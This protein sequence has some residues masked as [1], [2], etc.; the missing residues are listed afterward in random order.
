MTPNMMNTHVDY[1]VQDDILLGIAKRTMQN[2]NE[3]VMD[4]Y[5]NAARAVADDCGVPVCDVYAK[6]KRLSELNVN[7]TALLSNYINHPTREMN[8]LFAYSLFDTI[9]S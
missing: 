2:Q 4:A 7:T 1:R 9:L 8:Y 5:M 6:W 3:G